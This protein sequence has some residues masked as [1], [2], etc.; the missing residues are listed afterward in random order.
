MSQ[1]M[2]GCTVDGSIKPMVKGTKGINEKAE[3]IAP[4]W[5][6]LK[7]DYPLAP[8]EYAAKASAM[9]PLASVSIVCQK[10]IDM[11]GTI[12]TV[13]VQSYVAGVPTD[14]DFDLS[15]FAFQ[16]SQ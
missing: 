10:L 7:L 2:I 11:T 13:D 6:R 14:L 1:Q 12:A 5:V 9:E 15:I 3:R 16:R 4:G 8:K